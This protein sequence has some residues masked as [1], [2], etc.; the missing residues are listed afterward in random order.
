MN[1]EREQAGEPLFANPR[2]A[3]AGAIRTLDSAA[4]ARRGLE[5]LLLPGRPPGRHRRLPPPRTRRCWSG[6]R[7]GDFRSRSTGS[8]ARASTT[9]V[10]FCEKWRDAR[11][12]AAVRNRRRRHQ[13]RRPGQ[14]RPARHHGE[15]SAVGDGLQVSGRA[16][17]HPAAP[18]RSERG[19]HRRRDPVCRARAREAQRHDR[20][21]GHA[22]QRAGGRHAATSG[23][24]TR[25]SSK[26]AATSSRKSSAPSSPSGPT[27][28]RAWQMPR[29][30][31][32]AAATL[33]KPEEEVVWRCEN[34]SCPARIAA[35][36]A[37][38]RVAPRDEHRRPGRIACRSA[39]HARSW[40]VTMRTSTP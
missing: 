18:D 7:R 39:R 5:R 23:R 2:N 38:L 30:A 28:S 12:P 33:V 9:V 6:W 26:R 32:P 40:F 36:P 25:S 8:C 20:A 1:E 14:P 37:A 29:T 22:A 19:P 35:G 10:A 24:A 13:A 17:D 34:A 21:D 11:H 4:V 16:G 27:D 31:R 15:I 3:A